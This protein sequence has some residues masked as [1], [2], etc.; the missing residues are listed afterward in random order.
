[1]GFG[2]GE[3]GGITLRLRL[4]GAVPSIGA[5]KESLKKTGD[6]WT[7]ERCGGGGQKPQAVTSLN[8][9]VEP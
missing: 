6:L 2:G 3:R 7:E 1:M 8:M 5:A 9:R 4:R